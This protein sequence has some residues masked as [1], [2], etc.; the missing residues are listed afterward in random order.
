[1]RPAVAAEQHPQ[2]PERALEPLLEAVRGQV[3]EV[4]GELRH[5]ALEGPE[6][7]GVVILE[8]PTVEEAREWYDSPAYR[9]AREHRFRGADYRA[10][11]VDGLAE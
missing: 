4:G 5:E 9:Q 8:F 10:F 7:E 2:L 3:D 1:M 11:I 6:L